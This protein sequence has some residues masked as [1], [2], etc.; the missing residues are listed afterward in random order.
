MR[1]GGI[2]GM[3]KGV[4]VEYSLELSVIQKRVVL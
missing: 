3:G 4:V 2:R 1:V